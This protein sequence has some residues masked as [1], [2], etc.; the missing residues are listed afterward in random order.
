MAAYGRLSFRDAAR[1][2]KRDRPIKGTRQA[3]ALKVGLIVGYI[4]NLPL[5]VTIEKK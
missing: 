2:R 5:S 3:A 1:T 4:F